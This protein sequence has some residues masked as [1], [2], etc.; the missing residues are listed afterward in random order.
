[1]GY[2][3][4]QP[5]A[6]PMWVPD[7]IM[8]AHTD[9]TWLVIHKTAGFRTAQ[10]CAAYFQAGSDGRNASVHYIVGQ[11][12]TIV[13]CV[14]EYK[15]AGGNCCTDPGHANFLPGNVNLNIRT[16]SVEHIDP[17]SDNQ[18]PLTP[19]QKAA[20]F[21]LALDICNRHHIPLRFGDASG[22]VI[23][24]RDIAPINKGECPG[25]YPWDELL[26]FLAQGGTMPVPTGWQDER[27]ALIAPNGVP[28]IA[29]FK[30]YVENNPWDAANVP[31]GAEF[32]SEIVLLHNAS[33]GAGQVQLFASSMLWYTPAKGVVNEGQMGREIDA[34][35]GEIATLQAKIATLQAAP[36]VPVPAPAPVAPDVKAAVDQVI[37]ILQ[38]LA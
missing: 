11:D 28:V 35:Y 4:D 14:P 34:A 36:P 27:G 24:H 12:G 26:A 15:G 25:N 33:V 37:A 10:E 23:R 17:R 21:R 16:I 29:G 20:S 6:I 9:A 22:G 2:T 8:F 31:L 13:Q 32:H 18:T 19:A 30:S 7:T 1:M 38:P 3:V 5:G